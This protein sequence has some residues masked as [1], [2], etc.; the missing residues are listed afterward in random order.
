MHASGAR[1]RR[2]PAPV[3]RRQRGRSSSGVKFRADVDGLDHRHPLL[4]GRRQHRHPH[5]PPVDD[6]PA[7]CWPP[8]PSPARR[9]PAGSRSAS[10][11]RSPITANTTYVASYHAPDGHYAGDRRLLRDAGVDNAAAARAG[12]RRRRRQRRLPLRRQRHVPDQHL[13]VR[14]L[15]GRRRLHDRRR[16]P[17]R[18]RRRSP[19]RRPAAGA[20]GVAPAHNVT[21]TFSEPMSA[22]E[23]HVEH[24]RAARRRRH[25]R[26]ARP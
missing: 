17:T 4:Q 7:R 10:P 13:P 12:R 19:P 18:R 11:P 14:E 1:R 25:R 26:A 8:P 3:D 22:G 21:A 24:L 16:G 20:T 15:L 9:R 6:A 23:H 2:P 5:R